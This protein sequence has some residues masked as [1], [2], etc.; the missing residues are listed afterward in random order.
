MTTPFSDRIEKVRPS[1][2]L[3]ARMK[4]QELQG[5]GFKVID[6]TAGEPD[7]HTPEKIKAACK[8]AIDENW[9]RYAPIPGLIELR[10]AISNKLKRISDVDVDPNHIVATCGA[11][12]AIYSSLQILINPGDE[13]L[14]PS[15][16]WVTYPEQ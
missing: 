8:Q 11:K 2:T 14:V 7:F 3:K 15:P 9:T 16:F 5:Q 12:G 4:A 13:V 1:A 10:Q 6:L